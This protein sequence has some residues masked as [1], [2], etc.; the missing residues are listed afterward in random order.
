MMHYFFDCEMLPTIYCINI[1]GS[2]TDDNKPE[3]CVRKPAF[4]G[5]TKSYNLNFQTKRD[6]KNSA[7]AF[8]VF[9]L[10]TFTFFVNNNY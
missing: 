9:V 7:G 5:K 1:S 2:P 4:V 6:K 3:L 10:V 8:S